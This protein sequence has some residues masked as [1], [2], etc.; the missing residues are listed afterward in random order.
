VLD[1]AR[2]ALTAAG[3]TATDVEIDCA[4]V[5]G[6]EWAALLTE[7][8]Q[9]LDA[10]LAAAPSALVR[11][12]AELVAFNAADPAELAHFGQTI[13]EQALAAPGPDDPTY[14]EQRATATRQAR[15][16]LDH[17]L[18]GVDAVV[19]LTND[20][21]WPIDY[22]A[23]DSYR[24]ETTTAAAVAGY[25]AISVPGGFVAGL[26]VGISLIGRPGEDAALWQLAYGFEQATRARREP[27]YLAD[28]AYRA[29]A[30]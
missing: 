2:T 18:A 13:F 27:S 23:G 10:Y 29:P 8:R 5:E 19:T 12:L 24:I 7:F 28:S 3:A 20:P 14:Q 26:P 1:H 30:G 22:R 4:P 9:E 17:A 11:S 6:P 25:P 15:A 21:A 16:I